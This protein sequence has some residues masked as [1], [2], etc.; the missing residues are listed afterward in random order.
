MPW[1]FF[2]GSPV[3]EADGRSGKEQPRHCVSP[4]AVLPANVTREMGIE[5]DLRE[6]I[7]DSDIP[8]PVQPENGFLM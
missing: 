4:G 3:T 1:P 7:G 8:G 5:I 6:M 2:P